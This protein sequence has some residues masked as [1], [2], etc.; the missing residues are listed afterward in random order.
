MDDLACLGEQP[1]ALVQGNVYRVWER[2]GRDLAPKNQYESDPTLCEALP[3]T[4]A[5]SV[6]PSKLCLLSDIVDEWRRVIAP[7]GY[8]L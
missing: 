7:T 5:K 8:R 2:Q 1:E 4:C 6:C 3:L